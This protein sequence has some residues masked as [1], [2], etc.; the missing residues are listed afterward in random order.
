ML[1]CSWDP[2]RLFWVIIVLRCTEHS[3][4]SEKEN[5][6]DFEKANKDNAWRSSMIYQESLR[7]YCKTGQSEFSEKYYLVSYLLLRVDKLTR[8]VYKILTEKVAKQC[9]KY[10]V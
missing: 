7:N 4:R 5:C 10:I 2:S 3:I 9:A 6:G 1:T 8:T